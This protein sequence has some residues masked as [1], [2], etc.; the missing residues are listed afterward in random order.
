MT[1]GRGTHSLVNANTYTG[2][3]MI[4]DG[5]ATHP[6][7]AG[8]VDLRFNLA[9]A[10]ASNII[11]PSGTLAFL[12]GGQLT[13]TGTANRN[14]SRSF[15]ATRVGPGL[16][17]FTL[18]PAAGGTAT[19]NLGTV[20]AQP[21]GTL[22]LPN[23]T[24]TTVVT[25]ANANTNN[26]LGPWALL[27][28]GSYATVGAG[29]VIGAATMTPATFATGMVS[30]TENYAVAAA[31]TLAASGSANVFFM[32]NAVT[33]SLGANNLTLNGF[34]GVGGTINA[35][36]G[37]LI[38]G[39]SGQLV[40]GSTPTYP[41]LTVSAPIVDSGT[42]PGRLVFGGNCASQD[43]YG[44]AILSGSNS[45]SGGTFLSS[46]AM[47][48]RLGHANALGTGTFTIGGIQPML[49]SN[50]NGLT[51]ANN[52]QVWNA[53]FRFWDAN[54][55][56]TGTGTMS[57]GATTTPTGRRAVG[58]EGA[59]YFTV[60]GTI[61][62]GSDPLWPVTG[63]RK[64]GTGVLV[65][66]GSNAYTGS[67]LVS[68]GALIFGRQA[69]L[70]GGGT[71]AWTAA[72]VTTGSGANLVLGV[73]AVGDFTEADIDFFRT[74]A[75]ATS[76]FLPGSF[77]GID[78]TDV[79]S[80][81][82]TYAANVADTNG[83]ANRFGISKY[84]T[85]T[86]SLSGSNDYKGG[87]TLKAGTV[88]ATRG[89]GGD[90]V[91]G[92]SS[93]PAPVIGDTAAD[94]TVTARLLLAAGVTSGRTLFVPATGGSQAVVLGSCGTSGTSA[95]FNNSQIRLGRPV[96]L[97][98]PAGGT[99]VFNTTLRDFAGTAAPT[100][101]VSFGTAD[102]TGTVQVTGTLATGGMVNVRH[103][104]LNV[105]GFGTLSAS[106]VGV[107][108]GATPAGVG[109]VTATLGGAGLVAPGNSPGILTAQAVDPTGGLDRAFEFSGTAA[110]DYE[111]AES[112]LNDILRLTGAKPL[113]AGR[114]RS[115]AG[116]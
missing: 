12:G 81:T 59:G 41:N 97:M 3:T 26:I 57:L 24:G 54:S 63:L 20:T 7:A 101:D 107:D 11:A 114:Q 60:A 74:L 16:G 68:A 47:R 4:Q 100:V 36:T 28:S 103:G 15:A 102:G 83:G 37:R 30:G 75:T 49:S 22:L 17:F 64:T 113:T 46:Q 45:H 50:I 23:A 87:F 8:G 112:S 78:T 14:S 51:L 89:G 110:P 38:I 1:F 5:G 40:I 6:T 52:A 32:T 115:R 66:S 33:L 90:G 99:T 2:L 91:L 18:T 25:V 109:L 69:S 9:G 77:L 73:G 106:S 116:R 27:A 105:D 82:F 42:T 98:A 67:T 29:G 96:T 111:N 65:L 104:T 79:A 35:T 58:V 55:L 94:A 80:G 86:L 93:G 56:N 53:D 44:N 71:S 72:N 108:S 43:G 13:V 21:G 61:V 48:L 19:L 62:D 76:G 10:P 70:Y 34:S 39:D 95:S 85:G 31:G 92:E 88:V 84:G